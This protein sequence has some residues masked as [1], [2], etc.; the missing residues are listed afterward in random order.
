ME[1]RVEDSRQSSFGLDG[2]S[3]PVHYAQGGHF[4]KKFGERQ[5]SWIDLMGKGWYG[6]FGHIKGI[7][8]RRSPFSL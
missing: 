1:F 5:A 8:G 7:M 4:V 3:P 2:Y 6:V